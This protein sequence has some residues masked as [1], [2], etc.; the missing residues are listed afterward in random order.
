MPV[1]GPC[2][3]AL[4]TSP[5]PETAGKLPKKEFLLVLR[6]AG[7]PEEIIKMADGQLHD[8]V[9]PK[10]DGIFLVTHGL[11]RDQLVSRMGGSP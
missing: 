6:R 2:E 4:K 10:R 1:S 5:P 11:D 3:S 7:I 9:D 8:P